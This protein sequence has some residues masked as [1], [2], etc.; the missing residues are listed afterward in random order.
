MSIENETIKEFVEN[1]LYRL[2][3]STRMISIAFGN[4]DEE[5]IWVKPNESSNSIGN[6]ILHLCGN[7][8]QYVISSLG[9]KED[10]RE[11]DIE[12]ETI[13]GY[14]KEQLL[15]ALEETVK[16]AKSVIK[17]TTIEQWLKKRE[18]QG[19]HFSGI[20]VVLHVV[21]H[22]SY[23]TGQIAFWVKQLNNQPLGFYDGMDLNIK[24]EE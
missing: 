5:Q 24:N 11:R 16:M 10:T 23:H 13:S 22:Y 8:T 12:F 17:N 3:E 15:T 4:I 19:F 1:A 14:S 18:V 9:E 20:G 7:I 6:L 21:E 2:D